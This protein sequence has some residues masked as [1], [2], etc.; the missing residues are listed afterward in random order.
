MERNLTQEAL[1]EKIGTAQAYISELEN[2]VKNPS[3]D[4][5]IRLSKELGYSL[6]DLVAQNSNNGDSDG[7]TA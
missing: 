1:A 7:K 6:D 2:G 3:L 5:L 4:F